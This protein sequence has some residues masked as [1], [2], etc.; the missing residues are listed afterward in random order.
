LAYSELVEFKVGCC[1]SLIL[2]R[3]IRIFFILPPAMA[4]P[5][6]FV[7]D[8]SFIIALK[9]VESIGVTLPGLRHLL[10]HLLLAV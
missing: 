8:N 5:E 4:S 3:E 7:N 2:L 6:D 10:C 9:V 1:G